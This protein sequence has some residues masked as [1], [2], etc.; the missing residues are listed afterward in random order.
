V[1][2]IKNVKN[3]LLL[4]LMLSSV[5]FVFAAVPA[6]AVTASVRAPSVNDPYMGPGST[7][8]IDILAKDFVNLW[9][10]KYT[11]KY[12]TNV[13]TL[14]DAK[15]VVIASIAFVR[16][17]TK[18]ID[19]STGTLTIEATRAL[20]AVGITNTFPVPITSLIFSVDA[21]GLSLLDIQGQVLIDP[22]YNTIQSTAADGL[23]D[24]RLQGIL[25]VNPA[26][27][28]DD[29]LAVDS[30]FDVF[31]DVRETKK[32]WGYQFVMKFDGNMLAVSDY[33]S[34]SIFTNMLP[35]EVGFGYISMGGS[36]YFGDPTGLT[37]T[38]PVS[39]ARIGFQVLAEGVTLL[40][41]QDTLL[42]NV[43]GV[44]LVHGVENGFVAT[45][46]DVYVALDTGFVES[47][48]FYVSE[49]SIATFSGQFKNTGTG[50]TTARV[51]FRVIG[52]GGEVARLVSAL[53]IVAPGDTLR[54]S[55]DLDLTT[56]AYPAYY[57]VE[58]RV[59]YLDATGAFIYGLKGSSSATRNSM[60]KSFL[61]EA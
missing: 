17:V 12:N 32:L 25:S 58:I 53:T 28:V 21:R 20:G 1:R 54:A 59:Q 14:V 23:F 26:S 15:P 35:S 57:S 41:L 22:N 9:G 50:C 16:T 36:S 33:E 30:F 60:I 43:L 18:I 3:T 2:G 40:D 10:Y 56:I 7:F 42:T 46:H 48:H 24:N 13:L 4:A 49:D 61:V 29:T 6:F 37:T 39:V 38:D 34:L 27:M 8:T 52:L 45:T 51:I 11:L 55:A 44:K 5:F 19:D 47:H 31:V